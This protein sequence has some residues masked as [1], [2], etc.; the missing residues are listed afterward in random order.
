MLKGEEEKARKLIFYN[1]HKFKKYSSCTNI[2]MD[3]L[4]KDKKIRV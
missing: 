2:R 3:D 1:N 4:F